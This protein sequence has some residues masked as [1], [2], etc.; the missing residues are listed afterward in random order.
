[1]YKSISITSSKTLKEAIDLAIAGN[2]KIIPDIAKY[3]TYNYYLCF[4]IKEGSA[5]DL[6]NEKTYT[7]FKQEHPDLY[8]QVEE[9][10]AYNFYKYKKFYTEDDDD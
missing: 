2:K 3:I 9:W 6:E 10:V 8:N 7:A 1:M 5:D 4:H